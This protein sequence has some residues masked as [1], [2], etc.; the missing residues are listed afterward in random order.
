M[1]FAMSH[2]TPSFSKLAEHRERDEK[3]PRD[4]LAARLVDPATLLEVG[5][6]RWRE[7]AASRH[8]GSPCGS[9]CEE[10]AL[11]VDRRSPDDQTRA[12]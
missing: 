4:A 11:G 3:R 12:L 1:P 7:L 6:R 8:R 9:F 10:V 2:M 5:F